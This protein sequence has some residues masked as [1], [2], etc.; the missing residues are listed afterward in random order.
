M[1]PALRSV[2]V[3]DDSPTDAAYAKSVLASRYQVTVF[4]DGAAVLEA[5]ASEPPP[6]V[7]LLDWVMPG[8]SGPDVCRFLRSSEGTKAQVAILLVTAHRATDHVVEGLTSGANDYL[9]KPYAPEELDA[10]VAALVRGKELLERVERAEDMVSRLLSHA[11]D[12]LL[13]I[14]AHGRL[15]YA[16]PEAERLLGAS[17]VSLVGRPLAELIPDLNLGGLRQT[18]ERTAVLPDV[19]IRDQVLAPIA[20]LLPDDFAAS[21]TISLRN[22]TEAR[23]NEARRLDFY[24]IMAHDLRSPLS[25][26]QLRTELILS[27]A[28]GILSAELTADLRRIEANVRSMTSLINDFLELARLEG[29]G[30][31]LV[32]EELDA[33]LLVTAAV[34]EIRPVVDESGIRIGVDAPGPVPLHADRRRL[35]QVLMN[36]LANAVKFTPRG[37][38]I[39]VSARP[40][41]GSVELRVVDTGVG[42]PEQARSSLFQRYQRIEGNRAGTGLGLMIV[43][44]IVEAHG[45]EVGV[46]SEVGAGST[47]WVRMPAGAVRASSAQVLVVDDDD[48]LRETIALLLDAQGYSVA[49]A[50]NGQMA[51]DRLRTGDAPAVIVCDM[52]MP[53]MTGPELIEHLN[54]DARLARIPVLAMSGDLSILPQAPPGALVLQKPIQV[55]R[56]LDY[57]GRHIRGV[58]RRPDGP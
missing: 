22:V 52:K 13:V 45:G 9:V 54:A 35:L 17:A 18:K 34:E 24:S 4:P 39:T 47:F 3:V 30:Y 33:A 1:T 10:R 16:N 26:V 37:G 31:Q 12:S 55:D 36:L 6:D 25:A 50:S 5:L 27:G 21:A 15:T 48:D 11:P 19:R 44:E 28:R 56:L 43:R 20:R 23:R 29:G 2:W 53:I 49:T 14:D 58:R 38:T 57:V 51:L 41:G 7:L 42:I 32:R 8:V 40:M 46:T